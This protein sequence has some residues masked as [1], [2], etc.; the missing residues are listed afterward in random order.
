MKNAFSFGP[1][2]RWRFTA[3]AF[4]ITPMKWPKKF[5]P[6]LC[7]RRTVFRHR[8]HDYRGYSDEDLEAH[9][10]GV[11]PNGRWTDTTRAMRLELETRAWLRDFWT[12][13]VVAWIALLTSVA[14]L[15]IHLFR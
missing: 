13:G 14:S 6:G 9:V 11:K 1:R 2:M 4:T 12:K 10:S 15:L 3:D 5:D 8:R 7:I